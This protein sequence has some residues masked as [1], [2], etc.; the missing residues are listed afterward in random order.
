VGLGIEGPAGGAALHLVHDEVLG[1]RVRV[2]RG[3]HHP[4]PLLFGFFIVLFFGEKEEVED[5][6]AKDEEKEAKH[7][8]RSELTERLVGI[9]TEVKS[10]QGNDLFIVCQMIEDGF[11]FHPLHGMDEVGGDLGQ[12]FQ[13]EPSFVE[14]RV[15]NAKRAGFD[16]LVI[17]KKKIQ[18]QRAG[19]PLLVI[20][21]PSQTDFQIQQHMEQGHRG[22]PRLHLHGAVH[23]PTARLDVVFGEGLRLVERREAQNLAVGMGAEELNGLDAVLHLVSQIGADPDVGDVGMMLHPDSNPT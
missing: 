14:L 19:G 5:V 22:Q 6:E 4:K 12:R 1:R 3:I 7:D 20:G 10:K 18:V 13:N 17:I 15:G 9:P 16:D 2:L 8:E 11:D 21:S 23:I